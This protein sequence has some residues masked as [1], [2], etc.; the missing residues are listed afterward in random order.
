[1]DFAIL[2]CS[3]L[4]IEGPF[5]VVWISVLVN[6]GSLL[7]FFFGQFSPRVGAV[8]VV[9]PTSFSRLASSKREKNLYLS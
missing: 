1:M 5:S 9:M 2:E 6:L 4:A 7:V 8:L 3:F